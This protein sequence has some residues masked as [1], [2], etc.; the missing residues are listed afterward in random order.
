MHGK[1]PTPVHPCFLAFIVI[2]NYVS[3]SSWTLWNKSQF[4]HEGQGLSILLTAYQMFYAGGISWLGYGTHLI[5]RRTLSKKAWLLTILPLVIVRSADIGFG[6]AA[7]ATVSVA[8]QQIVKSTIPVYVCILTVIVLKRQVSARVCCTLV[9]IV[10]GTLLA[11]MGEVSAHWLGF[12]FAVLSCIARAGKKIINDIL[13]HGGSEVQGQL[14]PAQIIG[15]ESPFSGL[16]LLSIGLLFEGT[17]MR[18]RFFGSSACW[19]NGQ[20]YLT[21]N[22]QLCGTSESLVRLII[23]NSGIGVLMF[24]NQWTYMSIIKHTSALTCGILMNLKMVTLISLSI[25]MFGTHLDA[26]NWCGIFVASTGCVLYAH[27][28]QLEPEEKAAPALDLLQEGHSCST[29]SALVI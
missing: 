12:I 2:L 3:Y 4:K 11:A 16:I 25:F 19:I 9:P 18:E 22:A 10:G 23:T 15:Y 29:K 7:L 26:I 13:L 8:F 17:T 1:P 21:E 5:P 6:N 28:K 14:S 27:V 24:V 20:G